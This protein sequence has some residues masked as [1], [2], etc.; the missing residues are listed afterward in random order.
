MLFKN[1]NLLLLFEIQNFVDVFL[2]MSYWHARHELRIKKLPYIKL[3]EA[4]YKTV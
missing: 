4:S 3:V 1:K 2:D